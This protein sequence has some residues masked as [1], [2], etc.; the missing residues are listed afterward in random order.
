M[1]V[2]LFNRNWW[3]FFCHSIVYR[4]CY[5]APPGLQRHLYL[6]NNFG[7]KWIFWHLSRFSFFDLN[8]K[9]EKFWSWCSEHTHNES[10]FDSLSFFQIN[11]V[12]NFPL[13]YPM[14]YTFACWAIKLIHSLN[15]CL[16]CGHCNFHWPWE[17]HDLSHVRCFT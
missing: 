15:L 5:K 17:L 2:G 3:R 6:S 16:L 1:S 11:L 12:F 13:A 10:S 4:G 9:V 8:S 7:T 14:I